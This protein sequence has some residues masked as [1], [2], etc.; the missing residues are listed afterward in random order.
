MTAPKPPSIHAKL[1]AIIRELDRTGHADGLRLTVLK[2]WFADPGR[3][4]AFRPWVARQAAVRGKAG[5]ALLTEI[6]CAET[7][8]KT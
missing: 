4:Y 6:G 1:A 3:L 5:R 8:L 7:R 2:K